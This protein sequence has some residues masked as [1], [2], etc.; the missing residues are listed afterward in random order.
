M[1]NHNKQPYPPVIPTKQINPPIP[2]SY[3]AIDTGLS[4]ENRGN[5]NDLQDICHAPRPKPD[6]PFKP[7]DD[8]Q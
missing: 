6:L 1:N 4:H 2:E 7:M 3:P 8:E 5:E